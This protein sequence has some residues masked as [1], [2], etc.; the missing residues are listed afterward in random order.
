MGMM[1]LMPPSSAKEGQDAELSDA[2]ASFC[3]LPPAAVD[4]A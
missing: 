4:P 1:A 2:L 3:P